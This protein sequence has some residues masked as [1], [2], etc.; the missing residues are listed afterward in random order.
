MTKAI[1]RA[2]H[3]DP[4]LKDFYIARVRAHRL[5]GELIHGTYWH[6]GRGCGIGCTLHSDDHHAYEDVLGIP[7]S[8]AYLEDRIE[9]RIFES[10]SPPLDQEW[11]EAFLAAIPVGADLQ[12]VTRQFFLRLLNDP[13]YGVRQYSAAPLWTVRREAFDHVV[14]FLQRPR[15][16]KG[17][18]SVAAE[19]A[20]AARSARIAEAEEAALV[21][22]RAAKAKDEAW[23]TSPWDAAAWDAAMD[24]IGASALDA[25]DAAKAAAKAVWHWQRSLLLELLR[26]APQHEE[27]TPHDY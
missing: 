17:A 7:E 13:I 10:L 18:A 9:D 26:A 25:A 27:G 2:F 15:S 24:A 6:D 3:N 23:G 19:V 20:E 1:L 12:N 11:P 21:A 16:A 4:A 22:A 8:L 5:A 14:K